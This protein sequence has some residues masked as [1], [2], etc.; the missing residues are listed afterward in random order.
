MRILSKGS[1]GALQRP[2]D[3]RGTPQPKFRPVFAVP[4]ALEAA[5]SERDDLT[6]MNIDRLVSGQIGP[7]EFFSGSADPFL[8]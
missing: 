1:R 4:L 3:A 5:I 8:A 7:S 2:A 6:D